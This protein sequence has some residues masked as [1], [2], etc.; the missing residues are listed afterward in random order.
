VGFVENGKKPQ[1]EFRP[2]TPKLVVYRLGGDN[3]I[4]LRLK[5]DG[6]ATLAYPDECGNPTEVELGRGAAPIFQQAADHLREGNVC[7]HE[8]RFVS[9]NENGPDYR[10]LHCADCDQVLF[11]YCRGFSKGHCGVEI[12]WK[13]DPKKPGFSCRPDY[14]DQCLAA[15]A[16][17]D[18]QCRIRREER[19]AKEA[20]RRAEAKAK[21]EAAKAASVA[22]A[23][24]PK[25]EAVQ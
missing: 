23:T 9:I 6:T 15:K 1:P 8:K 19:G 7:I 12:L 17:C 24:K 21:R 2:V 18:E 25:P 13:P 16:E 22:Q 14:C 4:E 11:H 10:R 5:E 20:R 3:E